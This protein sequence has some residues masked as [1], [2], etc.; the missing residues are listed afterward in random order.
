MTGERAARLK[1]KIDRWLW[2][3]ANCLPTHA[4]YRYVWTLIDGARWLGSVYDVK[5]KRFLSWEETLRT[6]GLDLWDERI[7]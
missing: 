7:A 5:R 4:P 2:A 3:R 6:P 1:R